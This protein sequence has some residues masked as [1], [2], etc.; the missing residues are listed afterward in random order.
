MGEEEEAKCPLFILT[1]IAV[2][3]KVVFELILLEGLFDGPGEKAIIPQ[4]LGCLI[5]LA[6][7]THVLG[8]SLEMGAFLAG[9]ILSSTPYR[10]ELGNQV[11]P[12]RD[13]FLAVA[14]YPEGGHECVAGQVGD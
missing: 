7:A 8:F 11:V 6:W 13:F 10:H 1:Y 2:K 14:N 12:V 3:G 4:F 5:I 9:F